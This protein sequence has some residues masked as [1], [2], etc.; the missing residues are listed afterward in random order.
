M[1]ADRGRF[2]FID[3]S[4][5]SCSLGCISQNSKCFH[6]QRLHISSFCLLLLNI[7]RVKLSSL[8]CSRVSSSKKTLVNNLQQSI[9]SDDVSRK[10][11]WLWHED[12]WA[13]CHSDGYN[14]TIKQLNSTKGYFH[15]I[16]WLSFVE[17]TLHILTFHASLNYIRRLFRNT[18]N[19]HFCT[20]LILGELSWSLLWFW[21]GWRA[22]TGQT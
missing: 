7:L 14:C 1:Q 21:R 19:T 13:F 17:E 4:V 3:S 22:K 20:F 15:S 5:L 16:S 9:S 10:P 6:S 11:F 12:C 18:N 2:D 8:K